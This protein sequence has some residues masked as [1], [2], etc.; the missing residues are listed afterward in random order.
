MAKVNIAITLDDET[1]NRLDGS[2]RIRK[3]PNRSRAI[4]AAIREKSERRDQTRLARGC[5]KLDP[6][7]EQAMAEG[8]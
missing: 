8:G 1:L 4:E 7:E 3:F 6:S 5:A 2:V